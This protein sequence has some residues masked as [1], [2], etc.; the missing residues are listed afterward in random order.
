MFS[1]FA[2]ISLSIL[3]IPVLGLAA[4][5]LRFVTE[6]CSPERAGESREWQSRFENAESR[7]GYSAEEMRAY[8]EDSYANGPRI[9]RRVYLDQGRFRAD[10]G[11]GV[12]ID[13]PREFL[14]AV[15]AHVQKVI[16]SG[17]AQFVFFSDFGHGHFF[18]PADRRFSTSAFERLNEV[19]RDPAT[20]LLYHLAEHLD[21]RSEKQIDPI[22][23]ERFLK[24]NAIGRVGGS[25]VTL[26]VAPDATSE[27]N[28]VRSIDGYQESKELLLYLHAQKHGCF[29]YRDGDVVRYFDIRI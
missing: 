2:L 4:D 27:V 10:I 8:F 6:N 19:L 16:E 18:V 17:A 22:L 12:S 21:L 25:R 11:N 3:L 26:Q 28:T 23:R 7:Y 1:R 20:L 15:Q 13:V 24:R 9:K 29:P 5:S 14:Q